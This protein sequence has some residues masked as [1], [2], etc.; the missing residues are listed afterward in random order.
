MLNTTFPWL[1]HL[2]SCASTNRWARANVALLKPG[3]VVFTRHQ[4][5]GYGQYGRVWRSPPGVITMTLVWAA[6]GIVP[7]GL[8]LAVGL[9]VIY[10]VED[11]LPSLTGQLQ[12]KWVNDLWWQDRKWGGILCER[13]GEAK[14]ATLLIGIGLNHTVQF[15]AKEMHDLGFPVS[16]REVMDMQPH[17]VPLLEDLRLVERIRGSVLEAI[18]LVIHRG[19]GP[20]LPMLRERDG[21]QGK[22]LT[23]ELETQSE[24]QRWLGEGAGLDESGCLVLRR[25]DGSLQRVTRGKVKVNQCW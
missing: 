3:D 16:L 24:Q 23:V 21:L 2:P 12:L 4:T 11:L 15:S 13:V 8:T 14:G 1:H 22:A 9:A 5:A 20:L 17:P 7:P 18:A 19:L 10:A 6:P 25:S